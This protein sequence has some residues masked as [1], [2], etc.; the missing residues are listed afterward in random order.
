M[1]TTVDSQSD[2]VQEM[3]H[4]WPVAA[5]LLGGTRAMRAAGVTYL[6]EWP[7]EDKPSYKARLATATLYPAFARTLGVMAGKPFSKQLTMGKDV[8]EQIKTWCDNCDLEGRNL[9]TFGAEMMGEVLGFG[10]AGVMVDYPV[11][12]QQGIRTIADERAAG[13]RPYLVKIH[14]QQ[15]LG[16]L[17]VRVNGGPMILNQLRIAEVKRVAD[18]DY[19][20]KLVNQV[21]VHRIGSWE[22]WE[23]QTGQDGKKTY[24]LVEDGVTTLL[25]IPFVPFYG[26]RTGFMTG[27]SPLLDLA[28]LNVKHWQSQSDQDT[29]LHVARVPILAIIGAQDASPDG[30]GGTELTVGGSA[31]VRLPMNA[32]MKYVEHTG[33]AID[34]GQTALDKLQDQMIQTGA[35]LLVAQPGQRSATEANND[36]EGN[37]SELQRI[38]EA[39]ED[40]L[41]QCLQYMADWAKLGNGGHVAL[42]KDFGAATLTDASAQ[43]VLSMQQSGL[44]TKAT[45]I[46]EQQRRGMLAPDI[47]ATAELDA[48]GQEGPTLGNL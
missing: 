48:V 43:L 20:V 16:W 28:H 21:R 42:F 11:T 45:A 7:N 24:A 26:R 13:V 1:T 8:P 4:D 18:G 19:G 29:I 25:S 23:E 35:E 36:A 34:A 27:V 17:A 38:T 15:I 31:A 6:P 41:D 46:R 44:I 12:N 40:S 33:A 2:E 37:K 22:L 3:S 32:E 14:H 47:D 30:T 5:A 39:F 9:H 10:L